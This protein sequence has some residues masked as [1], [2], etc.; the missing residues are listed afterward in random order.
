MNCIFE[1]TE[2]P[3]FVLEADDKFFVPLVRMWAELVEMDAP[4]PIPDRL[5]AAV[6]E[7]MEIANRAVTWQQVHA[8][9]VRSGGARLT[10]RSKCRAIVA[11]QCEPLDAAG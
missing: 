10:R 2:R 5:C 3:R 9:E 1:R 4:D 7:A 6:M 11:G 8:D